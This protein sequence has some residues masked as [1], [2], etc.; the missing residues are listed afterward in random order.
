MHPILGPHEVPKWPPNGPYFRPQN[1]YL[2]KDP[3]L[4]GIPEE[5]A[6]ICTPARPE[7]AHFG[8]LLHLIKWSETPNLP[9]MRTNPNTNKL[10]FNQ[11]FVHMVLI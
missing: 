10:V 7:S 2:K 8:L 11:C 9:C 3:F 4:R 5:S 1:G 6:L